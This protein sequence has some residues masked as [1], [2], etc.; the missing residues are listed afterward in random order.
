MEEKLSSE[1]RSKQ[2]SGAIGGISVRVRKILSIE[3]KKPEE[4]TK[5]DAEEVV[6]LLT[7]IKKDTDESLKLSIERLELFV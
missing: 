1:Y 5:K 2:I 4:F 7:Q 3:S 6:N